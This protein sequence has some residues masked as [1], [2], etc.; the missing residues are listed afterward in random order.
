MS[1]KREDNFGVID[2]GSNTVRGVVYYKK[3]LKTIDG[4]IAFKSNILEETSEGV[5]SYNGIKSLV[6]QIK[7]TLAY[8]SKRGAKRAYAFATSAMRDVTNFDEVSRI[9]KRK[10]GIEIELISGSK[11]AEY[12]YLALA[13]ISKVKSGIG[14]DLGGGSAQVVVFNEEGVL[15]SGSFP[16]GVKRI[17][18]AF[19]Q[20][21]VP[22]DTELSKIEEHINAMLSGINAKNTEVWFMGGTAKAVFRA[23]AP[24]AVGNS[25][26]VPDLSALYSSACADTA[27]LKKMFGK[28]YSTMPVGIQIMKMI[29]EVFGAEKI[30]ISEAGVR[31][32]YVAAL[33]KNKENS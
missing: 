17:R 25:I 21:V 10:T 24:D 14:V 7:K 23:S 28:R 30:M 27:V 19:C 33:Y 22:T 18:N 11:E 2:I 1:W 3:T 12:D 15:E 31:D 16:I 4:S 13:E 8:F 9:I 32:G 5:L 26:T 29:T 6:D 20:E